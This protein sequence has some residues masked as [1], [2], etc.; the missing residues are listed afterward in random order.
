MQSATFVL[1]FLTFSAAGNPTTCSPIGVRY[2][3]SSSATGLTSASFGLISLEHDS[4]KSATFVVFLLTFLAAGT[5][6]TC[7]NCYCIF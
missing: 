6:T 2:N 5:S 7:I 1:S 4:V 3:F